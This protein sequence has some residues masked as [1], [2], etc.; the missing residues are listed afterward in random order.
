[1]TPAH[2]DAPAALE[3]AVQ[4][5]GCDV[6]LVLH[7][8]R[9]GALIGRDAECQVCLPDPNRNVSR[10]HL[11]VSN[12]GGALQ[13]R[14]LS[15]VNGVWTQSGEVRPGGT[16]VLLPGESLRLADYDLSVRA[17]ASSAVP[18]SDDAWSALETRSAALAPALDA[19]AHNDPFGD[20][21]AR[22]TFGPGVPGRPALDAASLAPARDLRPFLRGLGLDAEA[23][24]ALTEGE[25][26]EAGA[27]ARALAE[28]LL[29]LARPVPGQTPAAVP[30]GGPRA[31]N[32]LHAA[33]ASGQAMR[34]LF[35]GRAAS[36]DTMPPLQA[37]HDL[38]A[39]LRGRLQHA[40]SARQTPDAGA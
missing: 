38:L 2:H 24:G 35:A 16:G 26:H 3:L 34:Y 13:F 37:V 4:G 31:T 39:V 21:F 27:V 8:G 7:A 33:Q 29:A 12:E 5:P 11:A 30:T 9:P 6:A 25:L 23:A 15:A 19:A 17:A 1:V 10:R 40:H 14:V 20:W 22:S 36:A 18:G 32:P 28:G